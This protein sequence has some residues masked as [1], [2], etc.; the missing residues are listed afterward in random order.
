M[1]T[2]TRVRTPFAPA[3]DLPPGFRLVSLRAVPRL[4]E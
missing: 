4:R 3:L 1:P 2:D